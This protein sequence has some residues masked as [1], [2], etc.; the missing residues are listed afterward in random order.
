MSL[1]YLSDRHLQQTDSPRESGALRQPM[2][3]AAQGAPDRVS[4][5]LT[6]LIGYIPTEV[7]TLY[8]AAVSAVGATATVDANTPLVAMTT[9]YWVFV[10]LTPMLLLI[11]YLSKAAAVPAP[12]PRPRLWPWWKMIAAAAAFATW[13]LAVPGNPYTTNPTFAALAGFAAMG[14]SFLLTALTPLV[15]RLI[16]PSAQP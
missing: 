1:N 2:S 15:E 8:V 6:S 16:G 14:V 13:A 12:L 11:L 4:E 10:A 7:V 3:E 5:V 9:V